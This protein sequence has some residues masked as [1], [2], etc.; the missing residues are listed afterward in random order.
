MTQL[1]VS[2]TRLYSQSITPLLTTESVTKGNTLKT[3]TYEK[4]LT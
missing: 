4:L 1:I 2:E 3:F